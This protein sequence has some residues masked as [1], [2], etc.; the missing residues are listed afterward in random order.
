VWNPSAKYSFGEEI[1]AH[2]DGLC[3]S[4]PPIERQCHDGDTITTPECSS[5]PI[6]E[7]CIT[8]I[9]EHSLIVTYEQSQLTQLSEVIDAQ[10]ADMSKD[11]TS[12]ATTTT[13][14]AINNNSSPV[15]VSLDHFTVS[16]KKQRFL[17][18]CEDSRPATIGPC[19]P[20]NPSC[21]RSDRSIATK[22]DD[23][24]SR[25]V[26]VELVDVTIN[27][28]DPHINRGAEIP[29]GTYKD[30]HHRW[31]VSYVGGWKRGRGKRKRMIREVPGSSSNSS[32]NESH[33]VD[34]SEE[35][36]QTMRTMSC[37]RQHGN[38]IS[39]THHDDDSMQSSQLNAIINHTP[40]PLLHDNT[41]KSISKSPQVIHMS[42]IVETASIFTALVRKQLRCLAFCKVRK[43]VE[44]VLSY[45]QRN[46]ELL[47]T[48]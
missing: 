42:S 10:V 34:H 5:L 31:E 4:L 45:S 19:G 30:Q 26:A 37:R 38:N 9:I 33:S 43:L 48:Q 16:P 46:L 14:T 32:P 39:S 36:Q 2:G 17:L 18:A 15:I 27:Q 20:V 40:T 13:T 3:V 23:S 22:V 44:L 21:D 11:T 29:G 7:S 28:S 47:G 41:N 1:D 35:M 25:R 8:P 6:D 24:V 12:T